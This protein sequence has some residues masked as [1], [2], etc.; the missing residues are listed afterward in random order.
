M[1]ARKELIQKFAEQ[2]VR[3]CL[4]HGNDPLKTAPPH[5]PESLTRWMQS[6]FG[7][8]LNDAS[9]RL[10]A[11]VF[12]AEWEAAICSARCEANTPSIN[13]I[14]AIDSAR[15][16]T[17]TANF[18]AET[19][20]DACPE[21]PTGSN[22]AVSEPAGES[23]LLAPEPP[24]RHLNLTLGFGPNDSTSYWGPESPSD[25]GGCLT[26][27]D[28]GL[29]PE[30]KRQRLESLPPL[31]GTPAPSSPTEQA[32]DGSRHAPNISKND[33]QTA[34]IAHP[35]CQLDE[36]PQD[37]ATS[38]NAADH[39]V[40]DDKEDNGDED[41]EEDP[42]AKRTRLQANNLF[43]DFEAADD[44]QL[45]LIG[46]G[47]TPTPTPPASRRAAAKRAGPEKNSQTPPKAMTS[48]HT[49]L[50]RPTADVFA[51]KERSA[52][53]SSGPSKR[54][55]TP[56]K[57]TAKVPTPLAFRCAPP[58]RRVVPMP[59]TRSEKTESPHS[60][61][62]RPTAAATGKE[63]ATVSSPIKSPRASPKRPIGDEAVSSTPQPDV[64]KSVVKRSRFPA[65]ASFEARLGTFQHWVAM[66]CLTTETLNPV[67]LAHAGFYH[68]PIEGQRD[69][70]ACF[71]CG[72]TLC[73]WEPKDRPV[74]EH[75]RGMKRCYFA[76]RKN[77]NT[78]PDI[79]WAS[80]LFSPKAAIKTEP[81]PK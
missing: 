61:P 65:F 18:D 49:P 51:G 31:P 15:L 67:T 63:S 59:P 37:R 73:S 4:R 50:K 8:P 38:S 60:T 23:S 33:R 69:R 42:P 45:L 30:P 70:C 62:K 71:Y 56:G 44:P 29:P 32:G 21:P 76:K 72:E 25:D 64:A 75:R 12:M 3:P 36:K 78:P 9:Q 28:I 6:L 1:M 58:Q 53:Q 74:A 20:S 41:E 40:R 22:A 43:R 35:T 52:S 34:P 46:S 79:P 5:P 80:Y 17:V 13:Q 57:A 55:T 77:L 26:F 39:D 7:C 47:S 16:P 19:P 24:Q 66:G 68:L 81:T 2:L 54:P 11:S 48:P 10:I 27:D 14:T